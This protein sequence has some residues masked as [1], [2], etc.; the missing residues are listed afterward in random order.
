MTQASDEQSNGYEVGYQQGMEEARA[1]HAQE[2]ADSVRQLDTLCESIA[3][4]VVQFK[5]QLD[6][7]M[8]ILVEELCSSLLGTVL[9]NSHEVFESIV[10]RL[11]EHAGKIDEQGFRIHLSPESHAAL[12]PHLNHD[13][14]YVADATVTPGS[15]RLVSGFSI[16][17]LNL[18]GEVTD[19]LRQS[20]LQNPTSDA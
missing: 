18:V 9:F 6:D 8:L 15:V 20:L 19:L 16:A 11:R 10:C 13:K 17:E 7:E 14:R 2:V 1:L 4:E 3:T 5:T 12:S